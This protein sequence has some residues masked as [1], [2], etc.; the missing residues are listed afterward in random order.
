M[1][2]ARAAAMQ[3]FEEDPRLGSAQNQRFQRVDCRTRGTNLFPRKLMKNLFKFFFFVMPA[4]RRDFRALR[5]SPEAWPS[6]VAASASRR[7]NTR[8]RR[9]R[10]LIRKTVADLG[11]FESRAARACEQRYSVGR[12]RKDFEEGR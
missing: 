8:W 4:K 1:R 3:I 6:A 5:L 10:A 11:G 2:K 12:E 7:K 9:R